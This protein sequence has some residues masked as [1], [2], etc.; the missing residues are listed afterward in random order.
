MA[1]YSDIVGFV[2]KGRSN[3]GALKGMDHGPK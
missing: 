1:N 2:L 3:V